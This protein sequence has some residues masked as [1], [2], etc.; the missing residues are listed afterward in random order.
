M[1]KSFKLNKR[2]TLSVEKF[3]KSIKT[4]MHA[5]KSY[6]TGLHKHTDSINGIDFYSL[7][8]YIF[9]ISVIIERKYKCGHCAS[10]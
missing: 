6:H 7:T 5:P 8:V 1:Y 10:S 4:L 3:R 2:T 9:R